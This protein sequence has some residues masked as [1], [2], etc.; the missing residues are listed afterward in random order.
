MGPLEQLQCKKCGHQWVPRVSNPR[1]CPRCLSYDWDKKTVK[2][3]SRKEVKDV[4][5]RM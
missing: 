2:K 4:G 1:R 3:R 5:C